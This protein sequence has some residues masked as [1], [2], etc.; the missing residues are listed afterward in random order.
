M[1][2]KD[3]SSLIGGMKTCNTCRFRCASL[4]GNKTWK[5][6]QFGNVKR[7]NIAWLH[8]WFCKYFAEESEE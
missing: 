8:G 1:T 6:K 4:T 3:L 7:F 5:C 2:V